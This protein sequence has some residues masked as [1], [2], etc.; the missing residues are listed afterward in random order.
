MKQNS[1]RKTSLAEFSY[2]S[3]V[4]TPWMRARAG[5]AHNRGT[6]INSVS[7]GHVVVGTFRDKVEK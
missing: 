5:D 2:K 1:F 4:K 3:Q 7:A 6:P